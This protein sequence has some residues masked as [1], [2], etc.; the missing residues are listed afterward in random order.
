MM[1]NHL[2]LFS[3]IGG[4]PSQQGGLEESGPSDF[5]TMRNMHGRY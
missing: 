5:V 3:G 4:L 2:D 1:L